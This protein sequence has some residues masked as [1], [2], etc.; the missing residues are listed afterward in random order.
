MFLIKDDG[1]ATR[2]VTEDVTPYSSLFAATVLVDACRRRLQGTETTS[3]AKMTNRRT[4]AHRRTRITRHTRAPHLDITHRAMS[5]YG[6]RGPQLADPSRGRPLRM[7]ELTLRRS[8]AQSTDSSASECHCFSCGVFFVDVR[9]VTR[10]PMA[11]ARR[12]HW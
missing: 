9:S 8:S 6:Q 10:R 1:S 2:R 7:S 4:A 11:S 5:T 3:I 12:V